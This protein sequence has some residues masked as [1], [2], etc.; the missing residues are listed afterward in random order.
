MSIK[1][2]ERLA[3]RL[4]LCVSYAQNT[5]SAAC[6]RGTHAEYTEYISPHAS[7]TTALSF[8]KSVLRDLNG[9]GTWKAI[10]SDFLSVR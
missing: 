2:V 9:L 6:V 5:R 1:S 4:V 10:G 3:V 8:L 7:T